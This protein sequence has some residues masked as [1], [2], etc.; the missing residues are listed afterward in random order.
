MTT[1]AS[2]PGEI[3]QFLAAH[4]FS[5]DDP[6]R[7]LRGGGRHR[8]YE[9]GEGSRRAALKIYEAPGSGRDALAR[10]LAFHD[11]LA[12]SVAHSIPAVLARDAAARCVLFEWVDGRRPDSAALDPSFLR[13]MAAF[14]AAIN[15]PDLR[16]AAR[17]AG[18]P[19]ASDAAF[20]WSGH[21]AIAKARVRAL[22]AERP[23]GAIGDSFRAFLSAEL[24][25]ALEGI[26]ASAA[27]DRELSRG[28]EAISPSD[29][30][31]HNVIARETGA[32]CFIDFEHAG[33]DDPAK[34]AADFIL[35][36]DCV[37][38]GSLAD[39][40]LAE[41]DRSG[42]FTADL[43]ERV[44]RLLPVQAVKWATIILNVFH[45]PDMG[46]DVLAARLD[47][48]RRYLAD[49]SLAGQSTGAPGGRFPMHA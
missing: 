30:G 27:S 10:E 2:A 38:P 42:L 40:F 18:L 29:F 39:S 26:A 11:L 17:R 33:W 3:R 34:M 5:S 14:L 9:V 43:R 35:Q 47:K 16:V 6:V 19:H 23:P 12:S 49:A 37:L 22:Q 24:E 13:R 44:A 32:L 21:L 46:G 36:P 48:A 15:A 1:L 25:P 7:M 4:G 41:L 20:A 31:F 45:R 28:E 8:V